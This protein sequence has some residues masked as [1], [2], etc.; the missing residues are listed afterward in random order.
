MTA[1]AEKKN[2]IASCNELGYLPGL[3]LVYNQI[4]SIILSFN[5]GFVRSE[6]CLCYGPMQ[7]RPHGAN[8]VHKAPSQ[9]CE[10]A[11]EETENKYEE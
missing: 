8:T 10:S 11:N 4:K 3:S 1:T 5:V 9:R 2:Q 7:L 6:F